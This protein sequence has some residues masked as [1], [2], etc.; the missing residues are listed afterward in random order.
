MF[1]SE[2]FVYNNHESEMICDVIINH[3]NNCFVSIL[4]KC[5][6]NT[7]AELEVVGLFLREL[8]QLSPN[9]FS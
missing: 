8:H 4:I 9:M 7:V 1:E 5:D 6:S 2:S 3:T